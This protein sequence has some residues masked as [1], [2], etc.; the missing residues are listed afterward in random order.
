MHEAD[1]LIQVRGAIRRPKVRAKDGEVHRASIKLGYVS[2]LVTTR[3][4]VLVLGY[5]A[6]IRGLRDS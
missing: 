3:P 5:Q 1:I 2:K 4:Q 6:S